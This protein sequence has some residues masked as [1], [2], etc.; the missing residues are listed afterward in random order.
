MFTVYPDQLREKA[1]LIKQEIRLRKEAC[2]EL[3]SAMNALSGMASMEDQVKELS[4]TISKEEEKIGDLCRLYSGLIQI[5]ERYE[6]SERGNINNIEGAAQRILSIIGKVIIE[7]LRIP[8]II[9]F[10]SR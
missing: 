3:R 10:I 7:V 8:A 2:E 4:V 6:G 5:I 9:Y 1:D